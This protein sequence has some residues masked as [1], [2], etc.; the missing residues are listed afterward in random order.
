MVTERQLRERLR[1][2]DD[3]DLGVDIVSLGL[4]TDVYIDAEADVA[5]VSLAFNAPLSPAE[6]T[7][8]DEVRALCRGVG[9]EP[10]I[11]ADTAADRGRFPGVKNT[12]AIGAAGPDTG[13]ALVT[14][15]L[16]TALAS[17]GARVGV[18]DGRPEGARGTWL[19]TVDPPDLSAGRIVPTTVRG[20]SVVRLEP[21]VP[22]RSTPPDGSVVLELAAPTV[23]EALE[24]GPVDYLLVTLPCGTDRRTAVVLE[25]VPTDGT[26]AVSRIDADP[27][28]SRSLVRDLTALGSTVIGV[29]KTAEPGQHSRIGVEHEWQPSEL[30]PPHLG[31]VALDRSTLVAG[32][33]HTGPARDQPSSH[34]GT[35]VPFRELALSIT[36]RIGAVNR[37]SV[38]Q[39]Q[40]P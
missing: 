10:R 8:C 21:V 40:L 22:S 15:N 3:P 24:W 33:H 26:I 38:A 4:V 6:W 20:I 13:T 30:G 19:D 12:I 37:Q 28:T 36:D 18:L 25:H 17:I 34:G 2:V 9:L 35:E 29:L 1:S 11:R 31:T 32:E 5:V 39:R 16:A 7:M 14:A 27:A 23:V